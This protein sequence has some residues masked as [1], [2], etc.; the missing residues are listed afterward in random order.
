MA[1]I[2]W[3]N[4]TRRLSALIPWPRNPRQ[5]KGEQVARLQASFEQFGQPEVIAIGPGNEVYNGHQRLKSWA[6]KFGDVEVAVRVSSR[7]L[8]EKE[9][10]KLT[11]FLH[12]GTVGE[13]DFDTLANEFEVDELVAWG[14]DPA[15]LGMGDAP[16]GDD[17]G[18]QV[19]KGKELAEKY[20]ARVGQTWAL[21]PHRLF[22]GSADRAGIECKF[23]IYDPPFDWSAAQQDTA[24]SWARWETA[25]LMGL[26]YCMPLAARHDFWHW[27]IWDAGMNRF[28][29]RGHRPVTGCAIILLFGEHSWYERQGLEALDRHSIDHFEWPTQVVHIQDHLAGREYKHEK[30]YPLADYTL[31]L[32]SQPGDI[33]GDPFAGSGTF[34]IAAESLKRQ[35]HG[36]EILPENAA[37]ILDRYERTFGIMPILDSAPDPS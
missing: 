20:G 19:D 21:G 7:P 14:F 26:H 31:S 35:Y 17:P 25:A 33:V 24:L 3:T 34:L 12:R 18:A 36:A 23:A 9:R 10:E 27:W 15:E 13:W 29:G 32:Y 6:A 11:V 1:D 22:V 2:T 5:I 37:V 16:K 8:T 28:G 4:D 30:P